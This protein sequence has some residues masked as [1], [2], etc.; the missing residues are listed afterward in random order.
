MKPILQYSE[1]AILA[2]PTSA[3]AVEKFSTQTNKRG[4]NTLN[5]ELHCT[6]LRTVQRRDRFSKIEINFVLLLVKSVDSFTEIG[7]DFRKSAKLFSISVNRS[8]DFAE[9]NM[10]SILLNRS[11]PKY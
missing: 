9:I 10:K 2:M 8:T 3:L 4:T 5:I 6:I 7:I 11:C 1:R